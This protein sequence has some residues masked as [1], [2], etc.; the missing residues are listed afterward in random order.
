M[1]ME[2]NLTASGVSGMAVQA[3]LF[4]VGLQIFFNPFPQVTAVHE[5]SFY[6]SLLILVY[7]LIREKKSRAFLQ[8][9]LNLP[10]GLFVLWSLIGL[11]FALNQ[12]NSIHDVYAH[13]V[14]YMLLYYLVIFS[15]RTRASFTVLTWLVTI[16][17]VLFSV[18]IMTHYYLIL[19]NG[20]GNRLGVL[21]YSEMP[22]NII[23]TITVFATILSACHLIRARDWRQRIMAAGF[24]LVFLVTTFA[25]QSKGAII[26][27]A[28]GM[29]AFLAADKKKLAL[30]VLAFGLAAGI[31][32]TT[33]HYFTPMVQRFEQDPRIGIWYNYLE[34]SKDHP[35]TGIGFGMQTYYDD[36]LL[37]KYNERVPA[38][39]RG[40][41]LIRAPHN[42][43]IDVAVRTGWVGLALFL[44]IIIIYL[45]MEWTLLCKRQDDFVTDW[46]RCAAAA[47]MALFIMGMLENVLSGP[48]A[49]ILYVIFAMATI[50]WK[51]TGRPT[52]KPDV[53]YAA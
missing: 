42:M 11:A 36:A 31:L 14:K 22:T 33:T 2:K 4:L 50:L 23:P 7:V 41:L 12:P 43:L 25:T 16:S 47:F 32:Q 53:P 30:F 17:T 8:S 39:Y 3:I 28:V 44:I 40:N 37:Q 9:P 27:F 38:A 35:V 19:G 49:I 15:I 26:A 45:R 29:L 21:T 10:F 20:F 1:L 5:L 51:M 13:L 18:G 34:I 48:P 6:L 46:G 24:I 52:G